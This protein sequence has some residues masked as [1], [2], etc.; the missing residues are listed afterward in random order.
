MIIEDTHELWRD[1]L[2]AILYARGYRTVA[3]TRLNVMMER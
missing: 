1:D 2:F 3:R